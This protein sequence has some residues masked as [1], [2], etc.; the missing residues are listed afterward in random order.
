MVKIRK[1][2]KTL[3]VPA[4]AVRKYTAAGW[5][6]V[7]SSKSDEKQDSQEKVPSND[8][9][10]KIEDSSDFLGD[11]EESDEEEYIEVDPEELAQRPLNT[12]DRE[13]LAILAEFKGVDTSEITS[14]KQLRAALR[15]LE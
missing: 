4:G 12:L 11:S 13:E 14:A 15:A 9:E 5:K 1:G 8:K 6:L 3:T 7:E 10:D 2:S